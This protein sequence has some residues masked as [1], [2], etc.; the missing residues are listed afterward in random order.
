MKTIPP[1]CMQIL[2]EMGDMHTA[3]SL[4]QCFTRGGGDR[5]LP[6]M[7][8]GCVDKAPDGIGCYTDGSFLH[9]KAEAWK[10]GGV[11][12]WWPKRE[13]PPNDKEQDR[14]HWGET[15]EGKMPWAQFNGLK[16]SSTRSET[17]ALML[18]MLANTAVTVGT[19]SLSMLVKFTQLAQHAI[20][21]KTARLKES[22]GAL[23][24]GGELSWLHRDRPVKKRWKCRKDGDLW[25]HTQKKIEAKG[26]ENTKMIKVKGHA[27]NQMVSEGKVKADDKKGNDRANQAAGK[28]FNDEQRR[29]DAMTD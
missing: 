9:V 15:A 7:P 16:G 5:Y 21:R 1:D 10:I 18:A 4:T 14:M 26:P 12:C 20:M 28:G 2:D 17:A 3:R 6:P 13:E 8:E 22:D 23:N 24:L 29:L 27:T 11:G 25:G 19:D